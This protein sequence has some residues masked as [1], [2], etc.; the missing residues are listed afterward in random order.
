MPLS[1]LSP[2]MS[3][4]FILAACEMKPVQLSS[5]GRGVYLLKEIKMK[6]KKEKR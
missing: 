6:Y 1:S 2:S 5:V 4:Y 3:L